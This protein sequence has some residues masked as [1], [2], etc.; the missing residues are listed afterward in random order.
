MITLRALRELA[1]TRRGEPAP[2][3]A[4]LLHTWAEVCPEDGL[5]AA[6]A[7]AGIGPEAMAR[8]LEP[9]V[10]EETPGERAV[11][12][13]AIQLAVGEEPSGAH[14]LRALCEAP[15]E[16]LTQALVAAG[17]VLTQVLPNLAEGAANQPVRSVLR[18]LGVRVE[19]N[20]RVLERHGGRDLTALAR[21]GA[22]DALQARAGELEQIRDVLTRRHKRNAVITGEAGT[23]KTALVESLARLLAAERTG[24]L[25]GVRIVELPAGN[26]VAGTIYRGEF[27]ARFREL[28]DE[29]LG[30]GNVILFIDEFHTVVRAGAAEGGTLDLA[31]LL[32]PYLD[33]AEL[34]VIGATTTAE[35]RRVR[36]RD[37]ALARRFQEVPLAEPAGDDLRAM[38]T[39]Q[40]AELSRHH[41]VAIEP[42]V[43]AR[44][45]EL[46]EQH[47]R[48]RRQPDKSVELLDSTAA[49][50][51]RAGRPVVEAGD[52]LVTLAAMTGLPIA[53]LTG[54][55]RA[56]LRDL[57][58]ALARTLVGQGEAIQR[59]A[60]VLVKARLGLGNPNRP[61]ASFLFL[62]PT[63]VGKTS[64]AYAIAEG[65]YGD[66]GRLVRIDGGEYAEAS[67]VSRLL[68]AAPGLVGHESDPPLIRGLQQHPAAV[69]LFD[70]IEK[71]HPDL[72]ELVLGLLDHGQVVSAR[73]QSYDARQCVVV[74][75][76]NAFSDLLRR[77]PVGFTGQTP[78]E[79]I[80]G[81]RL[82][83]QFPA[84]FL[85]R[86]DEVLLFRSL[87]REDI[88]EILR[89]RLR[90]V[91]EQFLAKGL[92][93]RF[94][95]RR[96]TA[97]LLDRLAG[98]DAAGA[99]G[100]AR[101]LERHLVQPLALA[102]LEAPP[103]QE[104]V[105][106]IDE[107]FYAG[108]PLTVGRQRA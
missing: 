53:S 20:L 104:T 59:V 28:M 74:S 99:R 26:L 76:S 42:A 12:L 7:G 54:A 102:L 84:E 24:P 83:E 30:A 50:V 65:V 16:R 96:L 6:L 56:M 75:T 52:L 43:I 94:D 3:L 57:R 18:T 63:G 92:R 106:E 71:A 25:A 8:A 100:I 1:S 23:G 29:V 49:R 69:I 4:A 31:N 14:L 68:G 67:A 27:E 82:R 89:R 78:G 37:P 107:A 85:G 77:G 51:A 58:A 32:K 72:H 34:R 87:A 86:L 101:L 62:G 22:F 45:I 70:E 9:L 36:E 90:A 103:G 19:P 11:R 39:R 21:E 46:S 61:L 105:V 55:D 60:D 88:T 2:G 97:T 5:E 40:A 98:E 41:G 13:R 47:L 44:A 35:W 15:D 93:L 95:E 48:Q 10:A 17:L 80:L 64:L 79:E 33:R 108:G 66:A 73:G 81:E 91:A 38:V